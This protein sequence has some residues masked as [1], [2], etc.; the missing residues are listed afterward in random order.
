[1]RVVAGN[2][3][4][5]ELVVE[6][7]IG[8]AF[9]DQLRQRFEVARQLRLDLFHVVRIQVFKEPKCKGPNNQVVDQRGLIPLDYAME[10]D[11]NIL[12][13]SSIL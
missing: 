12:S 4:V 9:D 11:H 5:V 7:R 1:M 6:D 10:V 3:E 13:I 2:L 8:L